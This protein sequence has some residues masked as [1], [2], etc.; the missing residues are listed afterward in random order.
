MTPVE[1]VMRA[2]DDL[3]RAGKVLYV[4]VSDTP[5][6]VVS[7]ANTMA[8][9]RGWT[10]FVGLQIR[11]SLIDRTAEADLLPMARE[12]D[13]AVTPWSILGAGV[14]SGKYNRDKPPKEGRAKNGAATIERNLKIAQTVVD[15]ADDMGCTPAQ[16]AI[17][18]IRSQPGVIIP[19][20]GAR[21]LRQLKDNLAALEVELDEDQMARLNEASR[22]DLGFPHNF[23]SEERVHELVYG[24]TYEDIDNH[25]RG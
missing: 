1:E 17:S 10:P 14:L 4:G 9:L 20:I 16:A 3:V 12:L 13:L 18:W 24:G 6:W 2:L 21:N 22:V 19:L 23:L 5:A 25:R 15:V 11:Y 8:E 7:R